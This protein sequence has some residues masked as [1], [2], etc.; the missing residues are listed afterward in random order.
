MFKGEIGRSGTKGLS[1]LNG[2]LPRPVYRMGVVQKPS[3]VHIAAMICLMVGAP[4]QVL[5]GHRSPPKIDVHQ[6]VPE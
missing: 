2:S 6:R 5:G 1:F 4:L 3:P